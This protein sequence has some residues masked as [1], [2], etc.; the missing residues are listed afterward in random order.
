MKKVLA[1]VLA[2]LFMVANSSM[3][4]AD[5]GVDVQPEVAKRIEKLEKMIEQ[6]NDSNQKKINMMASQI[7]S[8]S[9]E[10]KTLRSQISD[11]NSSMEKK[12]S[13]LA[14]QIKGIA[15]RPVVTQSAAPAS[16]ALDGVQ[17]GF[18]VNSIVQGVMAGGN[19][20]TSSKSQDVSYT[21]DLEISKA[22]DDYGF[23]YA[24]VEFGDGSGLDGDEL[25]VLSLVNYDAYATRN[26]S[27]LTNA[28]LSMWYYEHYLMDGKLT[29]TG[30]KLYV[31]SY[32]DNNAVANYEVSQF[33]NYSFCNAP[34]MAYPVYPFGLRAGYAITDDLYL[35][36]AIYDGD[37]EWGE[38]AADQTFKSAQLAYA[39][40]INGLAGNY[41]L[42]GWHTNLDNAELK[43]ASGKTK[44][45]NFGIGTS[46]D[47]QVSDNVTL[48]AR[49]SWADPGVSAI[50]HAVS[51]GFQVEGDLW[52]R[53]DDYVGFGYA[54]NYLGDQYEKGGYQNHTEGVMEI[55][56]NYYVNE[57]LTISPDLQLIWN[58][59]GVDQEGG[60]ATNAGDDSMIAVYGVRS[61]LKF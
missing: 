47:Q 35:N 15:D 40:D 60:S 36:L 17:I 34:N 59:A 2:A 8:L 55:Y 22:F 11:S 50:E 31:P 27:G 16:S 44:Q 18:G 4:F 29:L 58:P 39:A 7:E 42:Y 30:G 49:Y 1:V 21:A 24:L 19:T 56:Y 20:A 43:N 41:R 26:S 57:H 33:L 61:Y 23:A 10:N 13:V 9:A 5:E 28:T 32:I 45:V 37:S 46:I 48:F 25:S 51:G 6:M 14:S 53:A 54:A 12:T 3:S 38:D 52:N